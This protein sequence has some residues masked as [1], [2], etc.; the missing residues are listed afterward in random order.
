MNMDSRKLSGFLYKNAQMGL[1]T[2]P[3][4]LSVSKDKRFN[5]LLRQQYAFYRS[6]AKR[7]A[8]LPREKDIRLSCLEK[9][10]VAAMIRFNTLPHPR[11]AT[12]NLARHCGRQAQNQ[13]LR[14][15]VGGSSA[16]GQDAFF[17]RAEKPRRTA[18]IRVMAY[19]RVTK[20]LRTT[21]VQ[22][23]KKRTKDKK[24]LLW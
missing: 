6:F 21:N 15:R 14:R 18:R 1:Y 16:S 10:R 2:I 4:L 5:A 24:P 17:T 19:A 22:E 8:K 9:L 13:R 3:M 12:A 20:N 11:P 7:T 23:R